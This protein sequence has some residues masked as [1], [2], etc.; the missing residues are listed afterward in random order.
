M[1]TGAPL[2]ISVPLPCITTIMDCLDEMDS[3]I[4]TDFDP[5]VVPSPAST[6]TTTSSF[7]T[8]VYNE[9]THVAT[10]TP[11]DALQHPVTTTT[12]EQFDG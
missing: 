2:G 7:T 6:G 12:M 11:M 1:Y 8:P 9:V 5:L 3:S 4:T 10:A